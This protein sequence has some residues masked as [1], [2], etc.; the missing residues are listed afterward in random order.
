MNNNDYSD[1]AKTLYGDTTAY[2]EFEQKTAGQSREEQQSVGD[3]LMHIISVFGQLKEKA[4]SDPEVQ[5]QVSL[6]QGYITEH[7]YT[8]TDEILAGLGKLYAAGGDFTENINRAGGE[9][10]A[11]FASEA[12]EYYCGMSKNNN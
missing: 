11:E 10:T 1:R 9:G 8:C 2:K 6:L 3:G 12:I 7:Y 5:T 4:A